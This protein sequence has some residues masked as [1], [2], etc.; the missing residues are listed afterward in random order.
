MNGQ[1]YPR[2]QL[3]WLSDEAFKTPED[4]LAACRPNPKDIQEDTWFKLIWAAC[5]LTKDKLSAHSRNPQYPLAYYRA[6]C[7]IWVTAARRSDEIRRLSVGCVSR[8][9]APEMVDEQGN[10]VEPAEELC[11]LRVPT[12]K[13]R[14]EFY[15][16]I[17]S[18]VADAIEVWESVRPPNSGG[19]SGSQNAQAD[20]V[21]VPV[22]P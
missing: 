19:V 8:E 7:L 3:T 13:M 10:Q 15:V 5:T 17:S 11:Y 12:N 2:L 4:I 18:Y 9:W 14:G 22:S 16:P 6:A 21:P 20:E 1:V